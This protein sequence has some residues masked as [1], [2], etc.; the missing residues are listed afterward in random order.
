MA[1]P[2]IGGLYKYIKAESKKKKVFGGIV[3][4]TDRNYQGRWIYF[5]R[6]SGDL[7][8]SDFSNWKDLEL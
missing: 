6:T 7:K 1:G 3:T 5:D 4:N 2:K 8:E